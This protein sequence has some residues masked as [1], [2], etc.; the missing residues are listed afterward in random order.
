M[1]GGDPIPGPGGELIF[2]MPWEDYELPLRDDGD[3]PQEIDIEYDGTVRIKAVY[4]PD[5]QYSQFADPNDG[6]GHSELIHGSDGWRLF[7][8]YVYI[9]EYWHYLEL[10]RTRTVTWGT[11]VAARIAPQASYVNPNG[12]ITMLPERDQIFVI[13]GTVNVFPKNG[14]GSTPV[15]VSA[16]EY[17]YATGTAPNIVIHGPYT[18]PTSATQPPP[19]AAVIYAFLEM[20]QN[21]LP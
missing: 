15:V 13:D 5:P 6:I 10:E 7:G 9:T 12:S 4:G 3:P 21:A 16:G 20:V 18:T 17:V 11:G 2:P 19:D 14:N 8:G 1:S